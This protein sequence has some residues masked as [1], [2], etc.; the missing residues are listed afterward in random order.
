MLIFIWETNL[1]AWK[2]Q[3]LIDK[4]VYDDIYFE[5][6]DLIDIAK[7]QVFLILKSMPESSKCN[8][9]K[10]SFSKW[11]HSVVQCI[12]LADK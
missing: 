3:F 1:Y 12:D 5:H 10:T 9:N 11:E 4:L 6:V 7:L 8:G 2:G